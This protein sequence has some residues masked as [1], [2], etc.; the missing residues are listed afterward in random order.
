MWIIHKSSG[1]GGMI[2]ACGPHP[3]GVAG[4]AVAP[5]VLGSNRRLL[6]KTALITNIKWPKM[7]HLIFGG[8]GGIRT[9]DGLLTHTPLAGE[10]L[11]PLG[12]L[13]KLLFF[14][15]LH[16]ADTGRHHSGL[17]P[18]WGRRR[19]ATTLSRTRDARLEPSMGFY[20]ILP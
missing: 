17:S 3:F 4:K 13:S 7:G 6:T 14:S 15:I 11:Q 16:K 5:A 2:R 10:R 19:C 20:P 8:E 18:L 12:H 1:E 9:L